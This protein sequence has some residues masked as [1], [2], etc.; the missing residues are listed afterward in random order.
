M[1]AAKILSQSKKIFTS[2]KNNINKDDINYLENKCKKYLGESNKT[3]E[4]LIEAFNNLIVEVSN[5]IM[6]ELPHNTDIKFLNNGLKKII[7]INRV[8]PISMFIKHVYSNVEYRISLKKCK[9]DYFMNTNP[10]DIFKKHNDILSSNEDNIKKFF[11]FKNYWGIIDDSTKMTIKSIM[12]T[13][14]DITQKYIE[15][16]DDSNDI[17]QVLIKIDT[18]L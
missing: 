6:A 5:L 7:S 12:S 11:E 9:D 8:E 3:L 14:I 1:I 13:I 2:D 4:K 15:I 16:K 10:N 17:A 18:D